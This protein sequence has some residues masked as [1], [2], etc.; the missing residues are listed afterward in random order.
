VAGSRTQAT[1]DQEIRCLGTVNRIRGERIM[2]KGT[3][4]TALMLASLPILLAGQVFAKA[5]ATSGSALLSVNAR[6][7]KPGPVHVQVD[8]WDVRGDAVFSGLLMWDDDD[9]SFSTEVLEIPK[10]TRVLRLTF[11]ND[12]YVPGDPDT[13]RNALIDYLAVNNVHY[14]AEAF[15]RTGGPDPVYP[16]AGTSTVD[17]RVV[18]D[19]G[20]QG[21]WI[22]FDLHPGNPMGPE[23]GMPGRRNGPKA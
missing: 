5:P 23:R 8:G 15:D 6:N 9:N 1:L 13:D 16:G 11:I 10:A 14:E 3:I 21:D 4:A 22:E 20:N 12:Y 19:C 18:A 2:R 17:G 7:D